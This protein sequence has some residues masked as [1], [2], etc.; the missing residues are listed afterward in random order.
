MCVV[1]GFV[2]ALISNLIVAASSELL[3]EP[4]IFV[5]AGN[6]ASALLLCLVGGC[7]TC[8]LQQPGRF[9]LRFA[10]LICAASCEAGCLTQRSSIA[11]VGLFVR[12]IQWRH[13]SS[14]LPVAA[15]GWGV[16]QGNPLAL[17]CFGPQRAGYLVS[18][19]STLCCMPFKMHAALLQGLPSCLRYSCA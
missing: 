13:S 6:C 16:L 4:A 2:I 14:F 19:F 3:A 17:C 18:C 7:C 10:L 15:S 12:Y 8:L 5:Q 1:F 9:I 11:C